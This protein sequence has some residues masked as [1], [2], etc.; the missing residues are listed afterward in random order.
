MK[1]QDVLSGVLKGVKS[2]TT[3]EEEAGEQIMAAFKQSH[4]QALR[5]MKQTKMVRDIQKQYFKTRRPS[6]LEA[7]KRAE[8]D[9]DNL[10]AG[11]QSVPTGEQK[12]IFN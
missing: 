2:G 6:V 8:T 1:F 3:S 9:L 7:S 10:L 12:Q 5:I 4:E 11:R